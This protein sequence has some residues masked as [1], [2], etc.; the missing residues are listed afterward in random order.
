MLL[1]S[2]VLWEIL[3]ERKLE[4][5]KGLKLHKTLLGWI[6]VGQLK[7]KEHSSTAHIY[8]VCYPYLRINIFIRE[9][10]ENRRVPFQLNFKVDPRARKG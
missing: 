10:L 5:E 1:G 3:G 2:D 9:I 8:T 7:L 4:I 6:V